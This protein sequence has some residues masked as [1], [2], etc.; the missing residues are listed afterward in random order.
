MLFLIL[1]LP[2]TFIFGVLLY[3]V[4]FRRRG[5]AQRTALKALGYDVEGKRIV[6]FFHPY[7]NAGG[8]GE[9]VLWTAL[10]AMQRQEQ[11]MFYVVYSGDID[12]TKDEIIA[13]AKSRFAIT[14]DPETLHFVF[15]KSRTLVESKT[16]PYFTLLGQSVGSM[17]LVWEAMSS[18]MP[19]LY[20]DT[21][22][23]AFTFFVVTLL[24]K[25]PVGAYVHYPTIST[26]MLDRVRSRKTWHTNANRV[27]ESTILSG[28]KLFYYRIFM[29]YYATAL[30]CASFLM[31]NSSWTKAHVD[32][33]L[34]HDDPLLDLLI[35][36]VLWPLMLLLSSHQYPEYATIVYPPC[37]TRELAQFPLEGRE[38]II[39]SVA[40]FRPEKDH[41]AQLQAYAELLQSHPEYKASSKLVLIGGARNEE[42]EARVTK[43]RT[44]H[45]IPNPAFRKLGH[46][47]P[48]RLRPWGYGR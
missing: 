32:S 40:Q 42:D 18:L 21:M 44:T 1:I 26:D 43:S 3:G 13:K 12:A 35:K 23:Y 24:C 39:L 36:L 6:G 25:I 37:D 27:A 33:I 11:D 47:Y 4:I 14:L 45:P 10:A 8:G 9:R 2:G 48:E 22:G 20:I 46:G 34:K 28:V 15:L 5:G 16:W 38:H 29:Y 30:R 17:Y 7:C 31:V 19:D 41:F